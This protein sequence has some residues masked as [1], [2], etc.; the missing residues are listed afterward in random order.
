MMQPMIMEATYSARWWPKGCSLSAGFAAMRKETSETALLPQSLKLLMPSASTETSPN[1]SP[2]AIF[3]P[4][5][6][7]LSPMPTTLASVPRFARAALFEV[8]SIS[9]IITRKKRSVTRGQGKI[10]LP[11]IIWA[12]AGNHPLAADQEPSALHTMIARSPT[13]KRD[14]M[15]NVKRGELYYG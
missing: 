11:R 6:S 8:S 1:K 3:A 14:A 12:A 15:M 13:Q 2:T 7:R 10:A 5:R 4:A 9:H